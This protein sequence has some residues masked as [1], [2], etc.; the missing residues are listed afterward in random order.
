[1]KAVTG[2]ECGVTAECLLGH[3][4]Q[5]LS[6]TTEILKTEQKLKPQ[7]HRARVRAH[8]LA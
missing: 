4:L 8:S 5:L 2:L 6:V 7:P 3:T 1:M